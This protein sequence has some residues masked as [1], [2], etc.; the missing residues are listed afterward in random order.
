MFVRLRSQFRLLPHINRHH[1][2]HFINV[3]FISCKLSISLT[4][5]TQGPCISSLT[6]TSIVTYSIYACS[7][8]LAG[9]IET[10]IDIWN[11]NGTAFISRIFYMEIFKSALQHFVGD[12]SR[13]LYGA[14]HN[15]F[16]VT[17]RIHRCPQNR[18]SD[19]RPQ[20]RELHTLLFTD[21]VWVL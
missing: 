10:I 14:V 13:L 12:F 7:T 4:C 19:A 8:V 11:G 2:F 16:S 18:M 6:R 5:L 17:S 3:T 20:Q 9:N 21:S 1:K 15:L